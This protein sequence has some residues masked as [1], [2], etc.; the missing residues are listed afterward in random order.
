M[1]HTG[2]EPVITACKTVV[3]RLHQWSGTSHIT[4]FRNSNTTF[5]YHT[6]IVM[7][8]LECVNPEL[9]I[10]MIILD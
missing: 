2:F 8:I 9:I 3:F 5:L 7:V 6:T 4:S 10:L 1:D